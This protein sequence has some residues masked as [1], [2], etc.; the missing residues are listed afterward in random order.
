MTLLLLLA[1]RPGD[2]PDSATPP[3]SSTETGAVDSGT[4]DT[5]LV[6]GRWVWGDLHAHSRW[7]FDG[8]EDHADCSPVGELPAEEFLANAEANGLDFVA[9]TDHAEVSDFYPEGLDGPALGIWAGQQAVLAEAS[10]VLGLLGYEWTWQTH[11]E[12]DGHPVGGHRTVILS[13]PAACEQARLRAD[14]PVTGTIEVESDGTWYDE[15]EVPWATTPQALWQGLDAAAEACGDLRWLTFAHHTA[16]RSP[17]PT[18]W[19]LAENAPSRER[20][21]EIASEHGVGECADLQEEGCG[22]RVNPA[23]DHVP[24]GAVRTALGL[25]HRLGFT[26]GTDSHDA[27]PGSTHDGPGP[28]GYWG[29]IT[30][31][32]EPLAGYAPGGLTGAWVVGELTS[33]ALFDALEARATLATTGPRPESLAVTLTGADGTASPPGAEL[34]AGAGPFTLTISGLDAQVEGVTADGASALGAVTEDTPLTHTW[35]P[36][37]GDWLYLRLRLGTG[38]DEERIWVSP[39]WAD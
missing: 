4:T 7:S 31:N 6:E 26:A 23:V 29:Q 5:G 19:D 39:W 17:Q 3:D 37:A 15:G 27:R 12:R 8:C 21:V 35:T 24:R 14:H 22:W 25:G 32:P 38:D 34:D 1:C 13:N 9:L 16:V 11:E 18:D 36:G 20:L 30:G 10:G 33:D 28:V 2:V